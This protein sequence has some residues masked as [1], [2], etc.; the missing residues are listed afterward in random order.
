VA[1]T[2]RTRRSFFVMAERKGYPD[3]RQP[4]TIG[5]FSVEPPKLPKSRTEA[6]NL[7]SAKWGRHWRPVSVTEMLTELVGK[8]F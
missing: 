8:D 1:N 2:N 5:D 6:L 7:F 4:F 3:E